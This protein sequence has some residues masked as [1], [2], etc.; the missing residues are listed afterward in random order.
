M[1]VEQLERQI[2]PLAAALTAAG[3]EAAVGLIEESRTRFD[4]ALV[5]ESDVDGQIAELKRE[6]RGVA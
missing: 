1:Q 6:M 3:S 4:E 2:V 5:A